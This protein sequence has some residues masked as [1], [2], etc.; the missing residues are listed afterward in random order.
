MPRIQ[1][2][3]ETNVPDT[4]AFGMDT[5]IAGGPDIIEAPA[6]IDMRK[7]A[8]DEAFMHEGLTIR[9]MEDN[10]ANSSKAVEISVQTGGITGPMGPKTHEFPEGT[11]GVGGRGGK[12]Y[13]YVFERGRTYQNIPRF[14]FEALAHAKMSTMRQVPH[15]TRPMEMMSTTS[16]RYSYNFECMHDPNPKGQAWRERVLR[17]HA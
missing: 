3:Y 1:A 4:P 5:L 10:D 7:L 17:D 2:S 16:H 12:L 9:I 6:D 13:K 8:E 14:I 11:P 15:P